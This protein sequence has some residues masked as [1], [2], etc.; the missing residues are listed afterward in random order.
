MNTNERVALISTV[1]AHIYPTIVTNAFGEEDRIRQSVETA[2]KIVAATEKNLQDEAD[3]AA[4]SGYGTS[5]Y[6]R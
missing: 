5:E 4:K 2:V 3:K 6:R 1:A